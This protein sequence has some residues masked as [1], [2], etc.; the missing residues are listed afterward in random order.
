MLL[1]IL[2]DTGQPHNKEL[3]GPRSNSAEAEKPF[4]R[5]S[6]PNTVARVIFLNYKLDGVVSI[7]KTALF[8]SAIRRKLKLF[9]PVFK[10]L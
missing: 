2:Q 8:S 5:V 3:P 7:L 10:A 4:H 6:S 1:K 9:P